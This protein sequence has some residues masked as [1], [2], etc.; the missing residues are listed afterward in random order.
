M[1]YKEGKEF[2][3]KSL[4]K[5]ECLEQKKNRKLLH[6]FALCKHCI[7]QSSGTVGTKRHDSQ[8]FG[9]QEEICF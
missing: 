3:L 2:D 7:T 8:D 6:L 9:D 4:T 5:A 1:P